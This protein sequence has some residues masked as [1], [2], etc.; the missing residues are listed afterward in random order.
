MLAADSD[1]L[2]VIR[3]VKA[4]L[5]TNSGSVASVA[6]VA[7]NQLRRTRVQPRAGLHAG[8]LAY[9]WLIDQ[10]KH[11]LMVCLH[12]NIQAMVKLRH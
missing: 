10:P 1:L 4:A 6:R 9:V 3:G 11:Q 8:F 2:R 5:N 12:T 7:R